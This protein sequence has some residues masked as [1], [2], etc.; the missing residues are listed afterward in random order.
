ML[1]VVVI[2]WGTKF[3]PTHINIL[4]RSVKANLSV[5]HN[6][7]CFTDNP[8]GLD[9]EIIVKPLWDNPF[10]LKGNYRKLGIYNIDILHSLDCDILLLDIDTVI[11]GDITHFAKLKKNTLWRAP[12]LTQKGFVYNTSLVRIVDTKF[13]KA[14]DLFQK[15][16]IG[17][18]NSAKFEGNW[19]GTDQAIISHLFGETSN[20]ITEEDGII[21]L[22]D[23]SN[24]CQNDELPDWVRI[25]SFYHNSK[26]GDMSNLKLHEK[27]PW[28][29]KH[30][31]SYANEN[32]LLILND[33][34]ERSKINDRRSRISYLKKKKL[35]KNHIR[36]VKSRIM[37][38]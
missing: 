8:N 3:T 26:Y 2:K 12:S 20:I 34:R 10:D 15:D 14:W 33:F 19:S 6:F 37:N 36:Y 28:L 11:T 16:H 4:Y 24:I 22:R 17:L 30:W 21:S 9:S 1:N 29:V 38:R 27:H 5:P 31:L 18:I 13:R 23:H 32:D 25:V 7:V 35:S